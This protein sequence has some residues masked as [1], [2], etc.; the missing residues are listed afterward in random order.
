MSGNTATY[1]IICL[2]R[3]IQ[4]IYQPLNDYEAASISVPHGL[5]ESITYIEDISTHSIAYKATN[6]VGDRK[7]LRI[8]FQTFQWLFLSCG[9][10]NLSWRER[11]E[12]YTATWRFSPATISTHKC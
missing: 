10:G 9:Y 8:I 3:L 7:S 1:G 2:F 6:R 12:K 4:V 11:V 5:L